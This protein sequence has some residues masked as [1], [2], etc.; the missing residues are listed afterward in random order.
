MIN[1]EP[2]DPFFKKVCKIV[3]KNLLIIAK[4]KKLRQTVKMISTDDRILTRLS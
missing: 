4:W 3:I 2:K 1:V